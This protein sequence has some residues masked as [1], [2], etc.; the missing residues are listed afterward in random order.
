MA[1]RTEQVTSGD[2]VRVESTRDVWKVLQVS[3]DGTA[4]LSPS[5]ITLAGRP[6]RTARVTQLR[7]VR[8]PGWQ[9]PL[10]IDEAF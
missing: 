4:V 5:S 2:Y 1:P 6:R 7:V 3:G 8:P 10:D 9:D